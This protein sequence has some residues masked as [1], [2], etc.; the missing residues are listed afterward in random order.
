MVFNQ[1]RDKKADYVGLSMGINKNKSQS[2]AAAKLRRQAE[3]RL[4][5]KTAEMHP[6]RTKRET[7]R[8]DHE[9]EVHQIEL[10]M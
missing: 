7:L 6:S 1:V 4:R 2:T 10:E 8:L 9:L 3:E 5:A